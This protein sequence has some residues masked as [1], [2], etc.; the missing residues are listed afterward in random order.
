M[1]Y[2]LV[3]MW[4]R[5]DPIRWIAG[6]LSGI[7]S[8]AITLIFAMAVASHYGLENWFPIKLFATIFLGPSAL[9]I[10]PHT[11]AIMAGI[12]GFELLAAFLGFV[13]AHFVGTNLMKALLPMGLVWGIFTWIFIWN[14]FMQSFRPIFAAR[15]PSGPVFPVC[16]L[17]GLGMA[18]V[19]FFDKALRGNKTAR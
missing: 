18:S 8:G 4:L 7:L 12:L 9:E 16:I 6:V 3:E 14:L 19:A 10:G 15:V 5:K 17:L 1:E 13:F 11:P 2:N